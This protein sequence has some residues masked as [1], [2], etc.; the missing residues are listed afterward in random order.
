MTG[1]VVLWRH[2]DTEGHDCCRLN[3]EPDGW[4]L[5]GQ[6]VFVHD[7]GPV[8]LSYRVDATTDWRTTSALVAGW[9]GSDEIDIRIVHFDSGAWLFNDT[10]QDLPSNIVDLD[11]GFT[12]ATNLLPL[13]RLPLD[14][15]ARDAAPAAYFD[16]SERRLSVLDQSY[17]RLD[18]ENYAYAAPAFGY[19]AVLTADATGFVRRYPHLF[20][21]LT[22]P[23]PGR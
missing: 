17:T 18:A 15:G 7:A 5:E 3:L 10:P 6:S 8:S 4:S 19:E 14:I 1:P 16:L 2:L 11:L 23:L 13:R 22:T 9:I 20:E 21:A 12:P